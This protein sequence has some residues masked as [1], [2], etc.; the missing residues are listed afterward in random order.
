MELIR[1][2]HNIKSHHRG[3]V[4]TIG[5]FDGLHLGHQKIIAQLKLKAQQ[6]NLPTLVITF[7]PLPHE[8]FRG[9]TGPARILTFREKLELLQ[10]LGVDRVLCLR[11]NSK[12]AQMSAESFVTQILDQQ[13]GIKWLIV[14]DDFH[15][16]YQR[17]GD[18]L[19]LKK[20][21][22]TLNF[23]V[24]NLKTVLI[25]EQRVG[26]S[27]VRAALAQGD[28]NLAKKLLGHP[29]RMSGRVIYGDQ[30]GQ[31]LGFPTAN[32]PLRRKVTPLHGVYA[33]IVH[34]LISQ[35]IQGVANIGNR[36]TV[37]GIR[38]LLEVYL[39]NFEKQIY[40]HRLEIEFLQ[41][42]RDEQKF[43]SLELLQAQIF[44]DVTNA[45]IFFGISV[46]DS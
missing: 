7:E 34:G 2:I 14:G 44:Q 27:L 30:R 36:P 45:K 40:G 22:Q 8:Y 5:N 12:L 11:F 21:G 1:G 13:L 28:L 25:G 39:L 35:G 23:E 41:K 43:A 18:F 46:S 3:C 17:Q 20:M 6:L 37:D 4:A 29:F 32:I 16:G 33:V 42:L 19:L 38:S 9:A 31:K 10:S 26:S 15:F 24:S